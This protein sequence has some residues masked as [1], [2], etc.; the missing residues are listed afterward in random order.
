MRM[1]AALLLSAALAISVGFVSALAAGKLERR[2]SSAGGVMVAVQPLDL[3]PGAKSWDFE[4]TMNTHT[5][6]LE[7]DVTKV[8]VLVDT[9]GAS[10]APTAWQGD[11]PGGHHR[12]GVL[13]FAPLPG[14]PAFVELQIRGVGTPEAR[15][16]KWQLR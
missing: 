4:V 1:R 8:S 6:P 12:K 5:T 10:H 16:F 3:A 2:T 13:R 7:Q 11:P 15:T 9:A 14:S